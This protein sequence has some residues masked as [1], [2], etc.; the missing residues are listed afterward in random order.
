MNNLEKHINFLNLLNET[1]PPQKKALIETSSLPQIETLCE[2]VLNILT[3]TVDLDILTRQKIRRSKPHLEIVLRKST[4]KRRKQILF[5]KNLK[6]L[7]LCLKIVL[8]IFNKK[9]DDTPS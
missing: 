7:E 1:H 6:L 9:R 8:N 2:I 3:G 5:L 4:S